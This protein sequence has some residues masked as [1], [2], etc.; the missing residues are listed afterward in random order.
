MNK[1]EKMMEKK[2]FISVTV[3]MLLIQ[4]FFLILTMLIFL[5]SSYKAGDDER[6]RMMENFFQIYNHQLE[7]KIENGDHILQR[8][9][10]NNPEYDM[11]KSK[12][13]AERY[14]ASVSLK[15][16]LQEPIA[17]KMD[18]DALVIA[19][20]ENE[21]CLDAVAEGVLS[22]QRDLLRS[23]VLECARE[24]NAKAV[25]NYKELGRITYIYKMYVWNKKATGIFISADNFMNTI[26][27]SNLQ[28][29]TLF[30]TNADNR[31]VGFIGTKHK[32]MVVG[33]KVDKEIP[34]DCIDINKYRLADGELL[35]YYYPDSMSFLGQIKSNMIVF[36]IIILMSIVFM[37]ILTAY[38]RRNILIPM[39][40]MKKNM[41]RIQEGDYE[42]RI[43]ENYDNNEFTTL[44][45]IFNHLMD[46][47]VGLKIKSYEKYI[48]LQDTE[49]KA[50][51]L[52][53][54]PH[55]FLNALTTISS[56]SLQ[57]KNEAIK[58]YIDALSKNV[59]YMFRFGLH[60]VPVIE[61]I[62][63]VE[64]YFEM[65]EL[66]YPGSVFYYTD[67]S[68]N[69]ES[70]R[71]PQMLIHTII[72]NEYKYAVTMD[73][74]LTILIN[75]SQIVIDGETMLQIEIEDDG[76][77]YPEEFL[78][79]FSF[80]EIEKNIDG[81]RIGLYSIKRMLEIMYERKNL[82]TISNIEP[83]GCMNR[84]FIPK[85]PIKKIGKEC[86]DN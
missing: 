28:E 50:I 60:T 63:H 84:F 25:W 17:N 13:E 33:K 44:K 30:I 3:I 57:K 49:L 68:Q 73:K 78:K 58:I 6:K 27:N 21:I 41:V 22:K 48:E 69:L 72:E 19:E 86:Y 61:E 66:K 54:R 56:L 76:K 45:D 37:I 15:K 18:I 29:M 36:F 9:I 14:H 39:A 11:I 65:Q 34:K 31:L 70:W 42:H 81:E 24:G 59:R 51:K 38:L 85:Y 12:N 16:L 53:I 5:Y 2:S 35:S 23:F 10:Y 40:S 71:I 80:G 52:Q 79:E 43:I 20:A 64:N 62:R 74:P 7:N 83:H 75:I 4:M 47:I 8:I 26:E 77:G 67:I 82:F 46:E 1:R 55:F 32:N